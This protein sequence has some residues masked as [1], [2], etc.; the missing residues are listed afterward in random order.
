[1]EI[2]EQFETPESTCPKCNSLLDGATRVHGKPGGPE[3]GDFTICFYCGTCCRFT[4]GLK[5]RL[6]TEAEIQSLS[7]EIQDAIRKAK[8]FVKSRRP[9]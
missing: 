5:L 6:A 3:V 7:Q 8:L 9:N 1:M 2:T 4:P